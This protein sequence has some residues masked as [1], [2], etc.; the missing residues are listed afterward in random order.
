[1][2]LAGRPSNQHGSGEGSVPQVLQRWSF[3]MASGRVDQVAP[4]GRTLETA[5]TE[6][7]FGR[8]VGVLQCTRS[9]IPVS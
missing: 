6:R 2:K 3:P 7:T 1:M 5:G 8:G 4:K 9:V